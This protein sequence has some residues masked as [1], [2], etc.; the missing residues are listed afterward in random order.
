[1]KTPHMTATEHLNI[2]KQMHIYG[3]SSVCSAKCTNVAYISANVKMVK[4]SILIVSRQRHSSWNRSRASAL[5][6]L[7]VLK[8]S[9]TTLSEIRFRRVCACVQ[10]GTERVIRT[11]SRTDS[12]ACQ[13]L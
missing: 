13:L 2:T 10:R 3:S 4:M 5:D 9:V 1:M 12:L 8:R 6:D 7:D 11:D